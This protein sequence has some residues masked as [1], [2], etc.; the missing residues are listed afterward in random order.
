[1]EF[2]IEKHSSIPAITQIEEQVRLA[3]AMGTLRQGDTLPSIRDIE[4]Q[5][6]VNR[7]QIHRAYLALRRSGLLA[8]KR[9]KGTV[10]AAAAGSSSSNST[11]KKCLQ[12]SESIISKA[13]QF[14]VSPTAFGRYLSRQAQTAERNTPFIAYIDSRKSVAERRAAE[15][16][17]LWQVPVVGLSTS[18]LRYVLRENPNLR[19]VLC[20]HLSGKKVQ[21]LIRDKK[22]DVIPIEMSYT[23]QTIKNL[24]RIKSH[25]SVLRVLALPYI[26]NSHFII[27]QLRKWVKSPDVE[28]S[29]IS[30][31]DVSNFEK[32][33]NGSRY[34]RIIVDP[35]IIAHV[36][37]KLQR[38]PRLLMVRF[39]L[40]SA[41]L[42]NARIR[43][44]VII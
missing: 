44:G 18:E 15:I 12:L 3:V 23:E 27:E 33:L 28:I 8:L 19:K 20:N 42:E 22:T 31:G 24:A 16:S 1:M 5:T 9:G 29:S 7:G 10:I 40:D 17:S 2:Y 41:S 25:S 39:R 38:S 26:D 43:A 32:L 35:G 4:K 21:P 34:D 37:P 14:G 36:P 6:G 30:V 11:N 13:R